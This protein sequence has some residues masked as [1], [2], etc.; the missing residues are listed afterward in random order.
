METKILLE[1]GTNELEVLEF[2][3]DGNSYGI[4]VA[5]DQGNHYVSACYTSA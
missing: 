3:V 5:K 1:N 4:N 2:I